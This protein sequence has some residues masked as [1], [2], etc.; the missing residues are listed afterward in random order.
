[1]IPSSSLRQ[2][3]F[4]ACMTAGLVLGYTPALLAKDPPPEV[5]QDGLH[6]TKSTKSRLVYTKPGVVWSQYSKLAVLDCFVDFD[7]NWQRDYNSDQRDLS[8]R[9]SEKDMNNIKTGLAAE[10]KKVF[11]KELQ[12]HGNYPVVD[13]AGPEVLVVRPAIINL[14]VTAPDIMSA[15]ITRTVVQSAGSMTLY[16]ELWDSATNTILARAM[17]AQADQGYG[18][19]GQQANRVTNVY[20][21]QTIIEEWAVDLRKGLDAARGQPAD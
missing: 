12:T 6:L 3:R 5:S 7:K 10:F 13:T 11:I 17:D 20:A 1:M 4:M 15:G 21:A 16:V 14:R 8:R 9:V 2:F 19:W 18:T